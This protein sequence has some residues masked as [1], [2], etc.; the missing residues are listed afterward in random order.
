MFV[1]GIACVIIAL[2]L[3]LLEF[4]PFSAN[5][6]GIALTMFGLALIARDGY[7]ALFALASTCRRHLDRHRHHPGQLVL[8]SFGFFRFF[9]FLVFRLVPCSLFLVPCSLILDPT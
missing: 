9:G 3:P 4:I 5:L 8:W 1:I 6:A 7:L 2:I